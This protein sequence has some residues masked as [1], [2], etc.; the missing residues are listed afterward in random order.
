MD[1][2][3]FT[4]DRVLL[5]QIKYIHTL[6]F[7]HSL[8]FFSPLSSRS[9]ICRSVCF[10]S[11]RVILYILSTFSISKNQIETKRHRR[12]RGYSSFPHS[13]TL[14]SRKLP[15]FPIDLPSLRS[16]K[17]CTR[18]NKIAKHRVSRACPRKKKNAASRGKNST[19]FENYSLQNG[20]ST[21]INNFAALV[22]ARQKKGGKK[23]VIRRER[24][25]AFFSSLLETL[26]WRPGVNGSLF[27]VRARSLARSHGSRCCGSLFSLHDFRKVYTHA[28]FLTV[29]H[30]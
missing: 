2:I 20:D 29:N 30:F 25:R 13:G 28:P 21:A 10:S 8:R 24:P 14:V 16:Y 23:N 4:L 6:Y 22:D 3:N 1:I 17:Y 9:F 19:I 7:F 15:S 5:F 12:R 27:G 18:D 26:C 11:V